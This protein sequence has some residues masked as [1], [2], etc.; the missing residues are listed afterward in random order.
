MIQIENTY[1]ELARTSMRNCLII[2]DRGVM[3]ASAYIDADKW[4]RMKSGNGWNEIE[5]RDNRY[6]QIVHMV[7]AANGAEEFYSTEVSYKL[8]LHDLIIKLIIELFPGSLLSLWR[9][10]SCSWTGLQSCIRLDWSSIFWCHWQLHRF[11]IESESHDWMCLPEIRHRHWRSLVAHLQEG[12]ISGLRPIACRRS[13]PVIPGL[14]CCSSLF[15]IE[16]T[17]RANA[18]KKTWTE[19]T[20]EV[21]LLKFMTCAVNSN[22]V[23]HLFTV[24]FI[25]H[26]VHMYTVNRSKSKRNWPNVTT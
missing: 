23:V 5:L 15:T 10:R 8:L 1:F 26:A 17:A 13:I 19:W 14:Q 12:Q 9:R 25:L 16:W 18:L 24:T 21:S 7:S 11:W 22:D 3:D 4:E 2:C 6:N 20:L